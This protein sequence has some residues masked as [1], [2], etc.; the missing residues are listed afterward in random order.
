M[1]LKESNVAAAM[2]AAKENLTLARGVKDF[3]ESLV[4][5]VMLGWWSVGT[6]TGFRFPRQRRSSANYRPEARHAHLHKRG[7]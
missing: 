6:D 1:E 2:T 3:I 5:E 4:G 7:L